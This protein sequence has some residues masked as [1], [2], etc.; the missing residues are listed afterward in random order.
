MRSHVISQSFVSPAQPIGDWTKLKISHDYSHPSN[1]KRWDIRDSCVQL[2]FCLAL[3]VPFHF[4]RKLF[5]LDRLTCELPKMHVNESSIKKKISNHWTI[6]NCFIF[7]RVNYL[8]FAFFSISTIG[9]CANA[10]GN[11]YQTKWLKQKKTCI[12]IKS[13]SKCIYIFQHRTKKNWNDLWT[14]M[15]TYGFT[16]CDTKVCISTLCRDLADKKSSDWAEN[17]G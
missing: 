10:P 11:V 2:K 15:L 4:S 13:I 8:I 5:Q 3:F 16:L 6:I 12:F 7:T 14:M 17:S 1:M 9:R